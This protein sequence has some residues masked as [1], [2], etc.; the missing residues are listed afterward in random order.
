[1]KFI[2]DAK[3]AIDNK[4]L[5]GVLFMDL[6]KAFD[7]LPHGLLVAKLRA[8]GLDLPACELMGSYLS[9]RKQRVKIAGSRSQWHS[10]EK[11][12]PQGSILGPL[13]FNIFINDMFHFIEKCSLYN[14]ADDNS[15]SNTA[16]TLNEIKCNLQHDSKICISWFDQNGM[17]ANPSKF[18]LMVISSRPT[19]DIQ[20]DINDSVSITSESSV[21]ALGVFI[22]NRLTFN[23]HIKQSSMKAA[24]QLNALSRIS[25]FLNFKAKKLI[26]KS[27]VMSNFT[28]S[29]LVWHFC[30]KNNN[31]KLEKIQERA[32]RIVCDDR[33]AEYLDL[34]K[35]VDTTTMLQSRLNCILLEVFKS[36][37]HLSPTYIQKMFSPKESCYSLRDSS[38]LTQ[39]KRNTTNYGLRTFSYL[40]SKMWND[41]PSELKVLYDTDIIEF[42]SRLKQ[43]QM[44][45]S[46]MLNFYV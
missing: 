4:K 11:G 32:L 28:Y 30:G 36:L 9:G 43:W 44:P 27:F 10:L 15:L 25:K 21:K 24:R 3:I 34:I 33:H 12:V 22:D 19:G 29:P 13:L 14:F 35:R 18:Q 23:E 1:M 31:A 20:L 42:K 5:V 2:E 39:P 26:F 7:C 8:Y 38:I 6:S 41:L 16:T 17:E 37:K 40:G 46:D 45:S